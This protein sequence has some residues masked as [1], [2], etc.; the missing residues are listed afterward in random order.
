MQRYGAASVA[1][2]AANVTGS[3]SYTNAGDLTVGSVTALGLAAAS[4]VTTS[5]AALTVATV[6]GDL[7]LSQPVSAGTGAVSLTAGST[8]ASPDHLL[9]NGV[10]VTAGSATLTADRMALGGT[11][12]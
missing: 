8:G 7:T 12:A 5:N 9:T 3:F 11:T 6:A 2:L 1:T 4:G 10:A